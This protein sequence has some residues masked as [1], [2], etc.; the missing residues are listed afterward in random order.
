M[1]LK[2]LAAFSAIAVSTC[3]L[4][5]NPPGFTD[6]YDAALKRAADEKK[7]ILAV[8]SGSDWCYWCKKLEGDFLSKREFTDAVTNDLV[9]LFVDSPN[10]KS[11]LSEKARE[12]NPGLVKKFGVRGF[13]TVM[14]IDS[15]GEK[16]ADAKRRD[17]KPAEWGKYLVKAAKSAAVSGPLVAKHIKPFRERMDAIGNKSNAD[18]RAV[19]KKKISDKEKEAEFSRIFK[20]LKEQ[21]AALKKEVQAYDFPKEI[22][23]E[24]DELIDELS[25]FEGMGD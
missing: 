18:A 15:K 10:D 23:E 13:P 8:F 14:F 1:N 3:A 17:M 7:T 24:K 16:I 12:K 9:C 4:G 25:Q 2:I 5:A 11:R 6:D 20:G 22:A 19:Q 21:F